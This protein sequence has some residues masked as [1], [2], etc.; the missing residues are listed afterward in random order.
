[1]VLPN[2][3]PENVAARLLC[4]IRSNKPARNYFKKYLHVTNFILLGVNNF[5]IIHVYLFTIPLLFPLLYQFSFNL[6]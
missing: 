5:S 2:H 1:M 3:N 6:Q 4:S